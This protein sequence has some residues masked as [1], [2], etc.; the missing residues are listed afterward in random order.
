M[1]KLSMIG[2]LL[3]ALSLLACGG[4]DSTSEG[5][6]DV[7]A[8]GSEILSGA[9]PYRGVSLAGAEF[10]IDP[11]GNGA[12]PGTFGSSYIYPDPAYSIGYNS[13][14]YFVGKGMTTFRLP[15][16]W[17]RLQP[18]RKAA[19]DAAEQTRLTTTTNNLLAKGAAV[20]LDAHNYARYGTTLIG[21]GS[22]TNADF[23]DFWGRLATLYKGNSK[24]VFDIMN[25]PHDMSTEQWVSAANAAIAAIRAT[26]A[27]NLIIVPGNGWDGAHSWSENWY[28]TANSTAMLQIKD[29]GNNYAYEVHQY[30]DD[31][32]A[33]S[34]QSCTSTTAGS[35]RLAGFTS[36]LKANG[37]RGFLGEFNGGRNATCLAALDDMLKHLE[38]NSS[39]WLGW[40]FWAA[41]P[42]WGN[43]V[44]EPN[45]SYNNG[46]DDVRMTLMLPHL[47]WNGGSGSGSGSGSGGGVVC[48][49]ATYE[50]E[51]MTH[52]TGSA[53]AGGWNLWTNGTVST[54]STFVAGP[55]HITVSAMGQVAVNVWPHM[56]V[57]V[58]GT[59][60]GQ[61][62]VSASNWASYS[63]PYAATAGAH[64]ISVAFNNDY[65]ANGQDRNL[66]V[67]KVSVS[68][69]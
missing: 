23:A 26:G 6:D 68:C 67:D 64:T 39:V 35:Q 14:S 33:G 57:S 17:E 46:N 51:T 58:D 60:I 25:E 27:N 3:P 5:A 43:D 10:A 24:V 49:A 22:V 55:T 9:L 13:A 7:G 66:L 40:T 37:K 1:K 31:T 63:F 52:S 62:T 50:A 36:W 61:A 19:F 41:G 12:I 59:Q 20:V 2:M 28:G 8:Q 18:T 11:S 21:S 44:I 30:L 42:W 34:S 53:T 56:I 45:N 65:Y 47:A 32:S 29:P 38:A 54:T 4:V 48:T 69:N 16:R 15:F